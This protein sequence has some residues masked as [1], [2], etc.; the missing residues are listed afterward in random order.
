MSGVPFT[1][2]PVSRES[3]IESSPFRVL[4]LRR[5]VVPPPSSLRTGWG[6]GSPLTAARVCREAGARVSTNVMLRDLDLLPQDRPDARRLEV[7]AGGLLHLGAQ[8]AI[9]TTM[10]SP[11]RRDGVSRP[12]SMTVDGA[13]LETTKSWKERR[14]PEL[15]GQFGRARLVVLVGTDGQ[16]KLETSC[17]T[18][19]KRKLVGNLSRSSVEP[20]LRASYALA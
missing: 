1:C 20:R 12:R 10:V 3:R 4:V 19:R 16:K 8:L 15:S 5:L 13:S 14:Y 11:L 7:V 18:W 9:D 6:V 2:F 17:G